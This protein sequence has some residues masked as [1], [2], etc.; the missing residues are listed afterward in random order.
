[1][2]GL[3]QDLRYGWRTLTKS[4]SFTAVAVLTLALGIG[5]NSSI[6]SLINAVLLRPLPFK[7]PN[8]LVVLYERRASSNDANL[9]ISGHELTS[10]RLFYPACYSTDFPE[11]VVTVAGLN[12]RLGPCYYQ[13]YSNRY[14]TIG[15]MNTKSCC[16]FNSLVD[17]FGVEGSS[18]AAPVASG[19]I[20]ALKVGE[21]ARRT[22]LFYVGSLIM[23]RVPGITTSERAI[24]GKYVH[25]GDFIIY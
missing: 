17:Q 25:N 11:N 3:V 19:R 22:G 21:P 20:G 2:N 6:F 10:S 24:T 1:M 12:T 7:D 16:F 14:V 9:P 5:V 13:N 15:V 4:R 18:Y 8:K 23:S